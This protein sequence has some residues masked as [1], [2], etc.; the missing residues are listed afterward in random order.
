MRLGRLIL[1]GALC[2]L[3]VLDAAAQDVPPRK[4]TPQEVFERAMRE[5]GRGDLHEAIR[6]FHAIL[7][8]HPGLNRARLEL[9]VAYYHAMDHQAALEQARR[10]LA[11]PATPPAVRANVQ[12]LIAQI[13]AEAEPHRFS[14]SGSIGVLYDSNVT[15]GP[16]SPGLSLDPDAVKRSDNGLTFTLGGAH[17]YL[18]RMRPGFGGRDGA[19]LWQSQALFNRIAYRDESAFDL[20]VLTLTTGPAWIS[21]PRLRAS[22]PVQF[23]RLELG[24]DAYL[25][26]LG[27]S[28]AVVFGGPADTEAQVDAQLQK[29]AYRRPIDTGRDSRYYSF[30]L[31]AGRVSSGMTLQAGARFN[32]DDAEDGRWDYEGSE[33]FGLVA[34]QLTGRTTGYLRFTYLRN[35]YDQPDPVAATGR[36]DR[37]TRF[38]LGA[39]YRFGAE[40]GGPW[41]AAATLLDIRHRSTLLVYAF[42]RRQLSLT[43]TRSL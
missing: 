15:A 7:D 30:G 6:S 10:V 26:M 37:E 3:A 42:D 31:Q 22:A 34:R 40:T 13:E 20:Q 17:R 16:S 14:G 19:L 27:V 25:D 39:S 1:P 21:P 35:D 41:S 2:V 9:A 43:L 5:R 24:G 32:R 23:D 11:D 33:W 18:S 29:R 12:G 36:T 38:A 8:E 4:E 28:P